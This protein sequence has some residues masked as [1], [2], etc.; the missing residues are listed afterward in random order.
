MAQQYTVHPSGRLACPDCPSDQRTF[1][2]V[3]H[4]APMIVALLGAGFIGLPAIV[5][6]VLWKVRN[7]DST[8]LDD[9]GK[10]TLN[11]Q[12]SMLIYWLVA[13][14]LCTVLIGLALLPVVWLLQLIGGIMA[15]AA[16]SRGEFFRYP[17][18]L[19]IIA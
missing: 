17:M 4:L 16:A 6:L 2:T 1:A 3:L 12:I 13:G 11:F 8:F 9:H 7:N 5:S 19:R 10:E 14:V 18:T 15:C